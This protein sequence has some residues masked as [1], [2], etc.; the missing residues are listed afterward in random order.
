MYYVLFVSSS[1]VWM[2]ELDYNESWA[3]KNCCFWSAILKKTLQSPLDCKKIKPVNP[4]RNQPLILIGRTD[5]EAP[6]LWP[7]D[8][9]SWPIEKTLMLG[10]IEGRGRRE[11]QRMRWLDCITELMDM[12]LS[13]LQSWWWTGKPGVLQSMGSQRIGHDLVTE[14]QQWR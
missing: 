11:W 10:K 1:H 6:V 3:P 4:K 14:Q 7:P 12:S 8:E 13:Q 9:K 2:W 5:A